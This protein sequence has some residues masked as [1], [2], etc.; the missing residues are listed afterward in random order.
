MG[1]RLSTKRQVPECRDLFSWLARSELEPPG[2][3]AEMMDGMGP[4]LI[5]WL[6]LE[7]AHY[8]SYSRGG[9]VRASGREHA[10]L[11]AAELVHSLATTCSSP[12]TTVRGIYCMFRL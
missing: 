6:V 8:L 9:E 11:K 4:P 12:N 3:D 7:Y 10:G 5:S 2:G 1:Q